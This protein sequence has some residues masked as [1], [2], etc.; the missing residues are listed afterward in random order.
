ML[1]KVK[2]AG[3]P[4]IRTLASW[5]LAAAM[6]ALSATAG[7]QSS[8]TV[9]GVMD[10]NLRRIKNGDASINTMNQDGLAGSRL[11]FRGKE[12]LGD[13]LAAV[14]KLEHGFA[15]DTGAPRAK[16]W[17][18]GS[19]VG[20]Q[21]SRWGEVR[22]GRDNVPLW[23]A[24]TFLDPFEA[25]GVGAIL[26]VIS[27]LG[28]GSATLVQADN[29][30]EYWLPQELGGIY[31]VAMVAANEGV[32]TPNTAASTLLSN[33][34]LFGAT[35]GY[36]KD[37]VHALISLNQ[38]TI[39]VGSPGKLRQ[40]A[41]GGS[42]DFGWAR[43]SAQAHHASY[44]DR[45]QQIVSIGATVPVG[46]G[47]IRF[48]YTRA[49]MTG[50]STVAGFRSSD[51]STQAAVEYVHNLSLRTA[52]YAAASK[53]RNNGAATLAIPGGVANTVGGADSTAFEAGIR[54]RF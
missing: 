17:N 29:A 33:N 14:F 22:L 10:V 11:G 27:T 54:H 25:L 23:W 19:Y 1:Q 9:Y 32:S 30:V 20:L 28:S 37:K 47:A 46:V 12:D 8:V 53:I 31:G 42:Y 6:F 34:K 41:I 3:K 15:P 35:L 51:D 4:E 21:S 40:A 26:N 36:Q 7:A 5:S 48:A 39:N 18:R 44:L 38:T 50:S 45:K 16:F 43:L 52:L 13:G 2:R 24:Y 49:D